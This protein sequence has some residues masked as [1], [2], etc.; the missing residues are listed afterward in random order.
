MHHLAGHKN[1]VTIKGAYEDP[2]Y[3]HIVMELCAGAISREQ[4]WRGLCFDL[5]GQTPLE[6]PSLLIHHLPN[7]D[8]RSPPYAP[9]QQ[10]PLPQLQPELL[11]ARLTLID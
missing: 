3:V 10:P 7:S 11:I 9:F 1:I 2:L 5:F 6:D 8:T 4:R